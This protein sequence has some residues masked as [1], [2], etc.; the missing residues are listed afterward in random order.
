MKCD[1]SNKDAV[2]ALVAEIQ[3]KYGKLDLAVNNA[4]IVGASKTVEEL[5]DD[6]WFQVIDVYKRQGIS[7]QRHLDVLE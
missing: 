4:G 7:I 5:E 6:D 3:E 2:K 1:V